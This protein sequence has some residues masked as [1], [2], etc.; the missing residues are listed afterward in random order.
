LRDCRPGSLCQR[1]RKENS[2]CCRLEGSHDSLREK[3]TVVDDGDFSSD[4]SEF[5][6]RSLA[7]G[8][9]Q[10]PFRTSPLK[11]PPVA[12]IQ[13]RWLLARFSMS[14]AQPANQ[15]VARQRSKS[16]AVA[17]LIVRFHQ[18]CD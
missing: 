8:L 18:G 17:I 14:A 16:Q 12:S 13:A 3:K 4:A 1:E 2:E 11:P 7:G 10:F 9:I 5:V 6:S 15:N